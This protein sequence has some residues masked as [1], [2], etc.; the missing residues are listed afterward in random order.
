M[1]DADES[2]RLEAVNS[3]VAL[4]KPSI[5]GLVKALKSP[6][7]RTRRHA[8]LA[9]GKLGLMAADA[10]PALRT[11]LDDPDQEVR[12]LATAALKVLK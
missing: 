11:C 10:A 8:T 3:L 2:V 9:L 12:D 1:N 6:D 4:G 5:P 7:V